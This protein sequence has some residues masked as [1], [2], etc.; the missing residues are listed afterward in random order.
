MQWR[1]PLDVIYLY[2]G[3]FRYVIWLLTYFYSCDLE[4]EAM[5]ILFEIHPSTNESLGAHQ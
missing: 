1:H 5:A 4:S 3:H 2:L